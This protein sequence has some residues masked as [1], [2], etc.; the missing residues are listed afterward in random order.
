MPLPS[1][2]L[3]G[4]E[5]SRQ[6]VLCILSSATKLIIIFDIAILFFSMRPSHRSEPEP[7]ARFH[8]GSTNHCNL[9]RCLF[10]VFISIDE[11]PADFM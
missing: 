11:K 3:R 2:S 5:F 8:G 1:Q 10:N 9:L 6:M 4:T 7:C